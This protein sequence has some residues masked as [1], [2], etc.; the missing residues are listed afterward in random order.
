LDHVVRTVAV[1]ALA[2]ACLVAVGC[3]GSDPSGQAAEQLAVADLRTLVTVSPVATGWSWTV[4]P[5]TRFLEPPIEHDE[6]PPGHEIRKT[7]ADA[8]ADA[9]LVA[10]AT[11]SWWDT[12]DGKKASS[13]ANLVATADDAT[14]AMEAERDFARRWFPEFEHWEIREIDADGIGE[15]Q[16]AVQGGTDETGFVEIG[17][18][19]GN[20]TLAVYVNCN[21]C[22]SDLA[23]AARRWA[24]AI[25]DAAR[26]AAD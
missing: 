9:G 20:A 3:G 13:F 17:W 6:S 22:P 1:S 10:A 18:T 25:D 23:D 12:E 5:R 11:S 24:R 19:R 7:L 16:W 26:A 4:D 2:C 8:Y 15:Q 21:P 14:R